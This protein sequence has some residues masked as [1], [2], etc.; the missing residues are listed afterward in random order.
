[1][2]EKNKIKK[3]KQK[4]KK[5][6]IKYE[7]VLLGCERWVRRAA[8]G[9]VVHRTLAALGTSD[10]IIGFACRHIIRVFWSF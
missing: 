8:R 6:K 10:L 7:P 1:M 9:P 3:Q 4:K 5:K 2:Y